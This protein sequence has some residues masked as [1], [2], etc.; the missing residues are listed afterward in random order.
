LIYLLNIDLFIKHK[1]IYQN[2][3]NQAFYQKMINNFY[4]RISGGGA[5]SNVN[6][7]TKDP[8]KCS[9]KM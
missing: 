6:L 9:T 7:L 8:G 5:C 1:L 2:I 4:K 3:E